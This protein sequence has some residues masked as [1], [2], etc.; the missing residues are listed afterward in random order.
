MSDQLWAVL[1]AAVVGPAV[2]FLLNRAFG[3]RQK[4]AVETEGSVSAQ[5]QAW[6][7]ELKERVEALEDD[8]ADLKAALEVERDKNQRQSH[9]MRSLVRWAL[10]LRDEI[11]RL[12]GVVPPAPQEVEAAMTNL[13]P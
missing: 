10:V 4:D 2:L 8:V 5:W 12:G 6:A 3:G 9:L 1:I 13:E 11:I 7:G